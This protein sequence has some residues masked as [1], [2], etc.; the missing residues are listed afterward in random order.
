MEGE[1]MEGDRIG[2]SQRE[3]DRLKVMSL[4]LEGKR[5]QREAGRLLSLSERQVRRI[6][7]KLEREGDEAIV[8][9]LR[10]RPSNRRIEPAHRAKVLA[11]YRA[12]LGGFGAT[13]AAEK[14][15]ER[16][17]PVAV[18]I[19]RTADGSG[20]WRTGFGSVSA[21]ANCTGAGG[22]AGRAGASWSRPTAAIMTGW[23]AGGLGWCWW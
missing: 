4:V 12:E 17:L 15:S 8:H 20:W 19:R 22:S 5:T 3:R 6:Q 10:G 2:M 7:R 14:L 18:R 16:G 11:R 21:K 9:K 13:F 1:R 23:R